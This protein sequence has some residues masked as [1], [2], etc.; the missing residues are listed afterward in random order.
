MDFELDLID[1]SIARAL[2]HPV[3]ALILAELE[4][5]PHSPKELAG[6]LGEPLGKVSY[7]VQ[8]LCE[9][10]LITLVR[11]TRR[12]GA[13]EHHY[14][15][16]PPTGTRAAAWD[17]VPR[18]ARREAAPELAREVGKALTAAGRA[19]GFDR[20]G[21]RIRVS[22]ACVDAEGWKELA[23]A[24]DALSSRLKEIERESRERSGGAGAELIDG[25][26][27]SAL[28]EKRVSSRGGSAPRRS[29][30]RRAP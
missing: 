26:V 30:A 20:A 7:H 13:I 5:G 29:R 21:S 11:E 22:H 1:P 2:A 16:K 3:R 6:S 9:L 23:R 24:L 12:R 15:A 19:G 10:G 28:A 4:Q 8:I 27:V 17:I 25:V 14:A 18:S